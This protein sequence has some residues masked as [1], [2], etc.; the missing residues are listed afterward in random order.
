MDFAKVKTRLHA[1][2]RSGSKSIDEFL[3]I[4]ALVI[5]FTSSP[6]SANSG[7]LKGS[8]PGSATK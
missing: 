6:I 8:T 1:A 5:S 2:L 3:D 7:G 4:R